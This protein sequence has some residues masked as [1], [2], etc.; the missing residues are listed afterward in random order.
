MI[1]A[2]ITYQIFKSDFQN[3]RRFYETCRFEFTDEQ[4][5]AIKEVIDIS[6]EFWHIF[7]RP[8]S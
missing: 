7:L 8:S 3:V 4:E 1:I 2:L 6:W 5:N